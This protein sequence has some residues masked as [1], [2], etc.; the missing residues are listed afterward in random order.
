[1]TQPTPEMSRVTQFVPSNHVERFLQAS[2]AFAED[3]N[4]VIAL[5]A[6]STTTAEPS[7]ELEDLAAP[8]I[9]WAPD[10]NGDVIVPIWTTRNMLAFEE[11]YTDRTG[12]HMKF[13]LTFHRAFIHGPRYDHDR[14]LPELIYATT[15]DQAIAVPG[16][17]PPKFFRADTAD[18]V[19]DRIRNKRLSFEAVGAKALEF[20]DQALAALRPGDLVAPKKLTVANTFNPANPDHIYHGI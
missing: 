4:A 10:E 12:T 17:K 13:A 20:V 9:L 14:I 7:P 8:E 5:D 19:V 1:M 16:I 3:H 18:L 6:I 2:H 15:P 11:D